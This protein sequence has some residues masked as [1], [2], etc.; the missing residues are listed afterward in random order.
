MA[1][2]G[3]QARGNCEN[4]ASSDVRDARR[5]RHVG[6]SDAVRRRNAVGAVD[7]GEQAPAALDAVVS[8]AQPVITTS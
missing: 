7:L 1:A 6:A 4:E 3:E 8:T 5:A 2:V